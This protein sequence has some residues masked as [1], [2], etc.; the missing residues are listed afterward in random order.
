M[1]QLLLIPMHWRDSV[2]STSGGEV[3]GEK[4]EHEEEEHYIAGYEATWALALGDMFAFD[5]VWSHLGDNSPMHVI[6]GQAFIILGR[7]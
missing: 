3:V 5:A 7:N 4:A 6:D 1:L 2:C